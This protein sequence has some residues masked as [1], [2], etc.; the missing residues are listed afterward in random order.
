MHNAINRHMLYIRIRSIGSHFLVRACAEKSHRGVARETRD[1]PANL[2]D[3]VILSTSRD[4]H[5]ISA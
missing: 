1:N 2:A 4:K 3:Y 5:R